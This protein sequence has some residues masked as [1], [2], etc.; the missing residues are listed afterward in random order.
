MGMGKVLLWG[1]LICAAAAT[2]RAEVPFSIQID[3]VNLTTA[4]QTRL[5]KDF[6]VL[7]RMTLMAPPDSKFAEIFGS[8][9]SSAV[10]RYLEERVKFITLENGTSGE[11]ASLATDVKDFALNYSHL[12]LGYLYRKTVRGASARRSSVKF[13]QGRVTMTSPRTGVIGLGELYLKARS[14]QMDRLDTLVHEARHS[15][16]LEEPSRADLELLARGNV[17]KM[18]ARGRTCT[19]LHSTCGAGTALAG[20]TACDDHWWG[21]YMV[22][23]FF[24]DGV[25]R[26]CRNC[27][28]WL[29]QQ[30][31]ATAAD[32][33]S[34]LSP[35]LKEAI[36]L[37]KRIPKPDMRSIE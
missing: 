1:T 20:S 3:R 4:Q 6:D 32:S 19:H 9:T 10:L 12:W 14:T 16:C 22:G 2:A 24:S 31:L 18:T 29:K 34:R 17:S 25:A 13:E 5:K 26:Y 8:G 37:K 11:D 15:D 35:R 7:D 21:A 36:R 28:S 30:A 27:P 23:Y 33:F